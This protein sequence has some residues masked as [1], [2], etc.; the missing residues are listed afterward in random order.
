MSI[1]LVAHSEDEL[2]LLKSLGETLSGGMEVGVEIWA[3]DCRGGESWF[4]GV[5]F[6]EGEEVKKFVGSSVKQAL[7]E[8][9][10]REW[11]KLLIVGKEM[12]GG[13]VEEGE[14]V[15]GYLFEHAPC[16][17]MAVRL[18]EVLLNQVGR[19]MVPCA[20]GRNSR[21]ALK[22]AR[23]M[24]SSEVVAF[25]VRPETDELSKEV[26]ERHLEKVIARAGLEKEGVETKVALGDGFDEELGKELQEGDYGFLLLGA[27]HGGVVRRKLFGTLPER[28]IRDA[29]GLGI[30]VVRA[31]RSRGHRFRALIERLIRV[32]V[33][34]LSRSERLQLF[35]EVESKSRWNF[36]FAAL[37]ILATT[38]ASFG[39]M[40]NS[41]AVVIG[42]MLVAPLMMPL[43]GTG[44]SLVQGNWPLGK[45]SLEAVVRGFCYALFLGVLVG[46]AGKAFGMGLTEQLMMRGEPTLFDL[47]IA[48]VSGVAASY[49]VARPRLSG[50]LAGVAIAAALVP[51]VATVG[52]SFAL[53]SLSV[54]AG[55]GLL[56]VTN[57][58]AIVLGAGLN[59]LMAGISGD[60]NPVLW[61]KRGLILLTLVCL[62]LAVPLTGTLISGFSKVS[63]VEDRIRVDLPNEVDLV[64]VDIDGKVV[65]VDLESV[66]RLSAGNFSKIEKGVKEVV[67]D[68]VS[69]RVKVNLVQR[70][71]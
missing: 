2:R 50:A 31:E 45:R 22:I 41:G 27:S 6:W 68:E 38:I 64:A 15:S 23:G 54:A 3:V 12:H 5:E 24:A 10:R 34:Q 49:C 70:S 25:Q 43:I 59:F 40:V 48:F 46:L 8:M 13:G 4:Q 58:I 69:V 17:V 62:G 42:A 36:D 44:L 37:M 47:A 53:G 39:L 21:S 35:D 9:V 7:L 20:G 57:I 19:V 51:P 1:C 28:M 33:P 63:G 71:R 60:R 11:P 61:G 56:F 30:G 65:Q 66:R 52:I 55:A 67:G 29:R 26:G 18:E 32:S 14:R 16:E